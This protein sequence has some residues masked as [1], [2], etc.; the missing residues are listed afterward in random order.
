MYLCLCIFV[1]LC[2]CI[3]E[4]LCIKIQQLFGQGWIV[5]YTTATSKYA[6][7]LHINMLFGVYLRSLFFYSWESHFFVKFKPVMKYIKR[8]TFS[9]SYLPIRLWPVSFLT[10]LLSPSLISLETMYQTLLFLNNQKSAECLCTNW[11]QQ[12]NTNWAAIIWPKF[13]RPLD[14]P[15]PTDPVRNFLAKLGMGRRRII[16]LL[17]Y[18]LLSV[19]SGA[20]SNTTR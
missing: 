14:K 8:I 3:F 17:D 19:D 12:T 11:K 20:L 6:K 16:N 2:I 4:Y 13:S 7:Q 1:Y 15:R 9:Q 5:W 10:H 18:P